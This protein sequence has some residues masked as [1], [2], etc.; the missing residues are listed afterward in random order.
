MNAKQEQRVSRM[1]ML[2][3]LYTVSRRTRHLN[4]VGLILGQRLRRWPNIDPTLFKG[5]LVLAVDALYPDKHVILSLYWFNEGKHNL[6][7]L[8]QCWAR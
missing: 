1:A 8:V 7:S 2:C 5:Y 4:N 6:S 3:V